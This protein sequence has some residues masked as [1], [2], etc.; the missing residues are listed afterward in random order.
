M[1]A[2]NWGRSH[3][4][5]AQSTQSELGVLNMIFLNSDDP[6]PYIKLPI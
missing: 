2:V 1:I 3:E 6:S 5:K 4:K